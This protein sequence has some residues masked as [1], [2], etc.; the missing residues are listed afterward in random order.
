MKTARA[1]ALLSYRN[2]HTYSTAQHGATE[3]TKDTSIDAQVFNAE[4]Y[5]RYQGEKLAKRFNAFSY[6]FLSK[7]MD[8]HDVGRGH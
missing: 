1:I 7:G 5:Q 2:Y 3:A 6:Y 8:A 4:T